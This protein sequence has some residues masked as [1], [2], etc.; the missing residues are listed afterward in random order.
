MSDF[1][2]ERRIIADQIRTRLKRIAKTIFTQRRP[3]GHVRAQVTGPGRGPERPPNRGWKP[4]TVPGLWGGFDQTTWFQL[5]WKVPKDLDGR[6]IAALVRPQGE[7]LVYINGVPKQGLDAARDCVLLTSRARA[8]DTFE[9][10]LES[11]PSVRFDQTRLFEYADVAVMHPTVWDAYWDFQVVLDVWDALPRNY[12][13]AQRLLELLNRAVKTVD[14]NCGEDGSVHIS[15]PWSGAVHPDSRMYEA[16]LK[17]ARAILREGLREFRAGAGTG[18]LTLTGH[19]HIDTA[20]LWPIRETQ[21]KCGRTFSTVLSLME[22]YPEYHFSCSQPAQYEFVKTHY[23]EL[24]RRIKRRVREGRWEPNG[25]F[26]V[27]PD[28]NI[29]SGESLVRQAVYGNRFFR[30]EFGVHSRIAWVPDT[31]G[32]CWGL[33]QIL[34]KAQVDFMAT[35]KLDWN[36]YTEFPYSLFQW[37][38]TDGSRVVAVRPREYNGN[39]TPKKVIEQWARYKQKDR[40]EEFLFPFGYGDGGGGPTAE[41]IENGRRLKDIIGIPRSEFGTMTGCFDR[42]VRQCPPDALPVWNGELYFELHRG[43]QTSQARNKRNN[44]RAEFLMRDAEFLSAWAHLYGC[45]YPQAELYACWKQLLTCQFHD[46]LPGT[47]ITE[48]Y[49][50]TDQQYAELFNTAAAIRD[51]AMQYL[52]AQINVPE[53]GTPILVFNTLSWAR[54]GVVEFKGRLPRSAFSVLDP[55]GRAVCIQKVDDATVLFRVEDVPP[56]GYAVYRIVREAAAVEV[57]PQVTADARFLENDRLRV[58]LDASGTIARILDKAASREVLPKGKQA[59]VLQFFEDRPHDWEAWEIDYNFE[60]KMRTLDGPESVE[61]LE[62]GPLRAVVRLVFDTG[63]SRLTQDVVLT[64]GASRADFAT[65]VDWHE[66]RTLLK[67]AFPVDVRSSYAA[68][69]IQFGAIERPTHRNRDFDAAQF[70]APAQKWADLSEGDYGVSLLND[71]KY[72]Y[73]VKDNTLRLSL[74]RAPADPDPRADEGEHRFVY[75]LYPHTQDWRNGAVRE[76]FDLNVPLIVFK[77]TQSDGSLEPE[78]SFVAL[79]ADHVILDTVKR[80][81]DS[82]ETIMRLYEAHGQR[83]PVTLGFGQTPKRVVECDLMEENDRSVR[84]SGDSIRFFITPYELRTFKVT[85]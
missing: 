50:W 24:Y 4:F 11:V 72:G 62:N 60:E 61:V 64:A 3:I 82:N 17:E 66:K 34:K 23:P 32:Y 45:R 75:S 5:R 8:G 12:A 48:V 81:E 6:C 9:L 40:T 1:D 77:G 38:G 74:L 52:A 76:A 71:C 19:S 15:Q 69:E 46:I 43:C 56:M 26:W 47:S 18:R 83:G 31:F 37:E 78:G 22:R 33:P 21:R 67:A 57:S 44:R 36:Q 58:E 14:L 51:K 59:N 29:P 73:D 80:A 7:S 84:L 20:W 35:A 85:F 13:P 28:L 30:K 63:K 2:V 53:G 42:I 68:F 65:V 79:D 39:I 49:R 10:L 70:E 41:M 54:S 25:C 27:E 16:S 55:D